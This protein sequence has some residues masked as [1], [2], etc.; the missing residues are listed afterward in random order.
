MDLKDHIFFSSF[1]E[2][3]REALI[4]TAELREHNDNDIIF[5]EGDNSES[6]YLILAGHVEL[7]KED[8]NGGTQVIVCQGPGDYFGE[9]GMLDG[10]PRSATAM[11]RD[12]TT[13]ARIT[14][15]S[16][17]EAFRES[18]HTCVLGVANQIIS[19]FRQSND[20]Q[21]EERLRRERQSLVGQ[22][23]NEIIHDFKNP[24]TVICIAASALG[25]KYTD[26]LTQKYCSMIEDQIRRM[27]VM[28]NELLEFS[29]GKTTLHI[30]KISLAHLFARFELLN[31]AYLTQA[32]ISF[33]LPQTDLFI[34][35]DEDK[36]LR[37]LQNLL[38]NAVDSM[39]GS[40]GQIDLTMETQEHDI[41]ITVKDDGPGIP[42]EVQTNLF[43]A[44]ATSG[45]AGGTG[46][47][48]AIVKKS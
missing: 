20:R 36:L 35:A 7:Q 22:M 13:L 34:E 27:E 15:A 29:R 24:F 33:S 10:Q 19:K 1:H 48:L 31:E 42:E 4:Q 25:S 39:N 6:I 23:A 5:R 21:I 37:I 41:I 32:D 18:P 26:E 45:R 47:G 2:S 8:A 11:T 40:P 14:Q 30:E 17:F 12:K 43:E 9:F 44:F 38:N 46:L 16:L 3:T 28:A